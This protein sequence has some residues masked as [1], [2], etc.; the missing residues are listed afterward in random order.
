MSL[1]C[2]LGFHKWRD[3]YTYVIEKGHFKGKTVKCK[4]CCLCGKVRTL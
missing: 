3:A 1:K 4:W 2:F